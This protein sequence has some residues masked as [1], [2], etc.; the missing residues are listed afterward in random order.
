[1]QI[2]SGRC[3]VTVFKDIDDLAKFY[4]R[5]KRLAIFNL[6]SSVTSFRSRVHT[7]EIRSRQILVIGQLRKNIKIY[8]IFQILLFERTRRLF[9]EQFLSSSTVFLS[10]VAK[11]PTVWFARLM[12]HN[13]DD[14][15]AWG[16]TDSPKRDAPKVLSQ[17]Q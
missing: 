3:T 1:M 14:V 17:T 8:F 6:S 7:A 11:V 16:T 4:K 9:V 13:F 15:I 10:V 12:S 2:I 5:L